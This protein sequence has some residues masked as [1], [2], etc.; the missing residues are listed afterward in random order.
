LPDQ[1]P[2]LKIFDQGNFGASGITELH[3]VFVHEDTRKINAAAMNPE[4]LL[5]R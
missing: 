5:E 2:G 3:P 1:F 4:Q